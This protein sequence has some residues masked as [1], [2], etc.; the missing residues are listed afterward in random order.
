VDYLQRLLLFAILV[1]SAAIIVSAVISWLRAS[2]LR[3]PYSNPLIRTVDALADLM[4][5]PIRNAFPTAAGGLDFSPMVAL[6]ILYILRILVMRL[7]TM[8]P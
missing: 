1:M 2:G 8:G 6:I 5:R 4:L 3:L 7:T